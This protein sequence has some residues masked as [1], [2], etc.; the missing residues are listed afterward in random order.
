MLL[1][2]YL[3]ARKVTDAEAKEV[4]EEFADISLDGSGDHFNALSFYNFQELASNL[5]L[6]TPESCNNFAN[7][8]SSE[9]ALTHYISD[10]QRNVSEMKWRIKHMQGGRG[11]ALQRFFQTIIERIKGAKAEAKTMWLSVRIAQEETRE[12]MADRITEKLLP[13][14]GQATVDRVLLG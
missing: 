1:C 5:Q 14:I 3:S 9:S 10:L 8:D 4:F 11:Y 2:H 7:T 6:F 12:G 13:S